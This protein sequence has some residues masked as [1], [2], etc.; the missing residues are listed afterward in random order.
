MFNSYVKLPD[1]NG[2]LVQ[3]MLTFE[4]IRAVSMYLRSYA[5]IG[6]KFERDLLGWDKQQVLT[7]CQ[8]FRLSYQGY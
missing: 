1:G 3:S 5:S 2:F 4:K 6:T 7:S 8:G